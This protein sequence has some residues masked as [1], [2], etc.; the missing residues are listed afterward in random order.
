MRWSGA[1][2]ARLR[3]TRAARRLRANLARPR[4]AV[5][6][7]S[8]ENRGWILEA[9]CRELRDRFEGST[10]MRSPDEMLPRA[11]SYFFSH[12]SL[13]LRTLA[14]Q[15]DVLPQR[16][17]VLFTHPPDS[18]S[19]TTLARALNRSRAVVSMSSVHGRALI[20]NGLDPSKLL[21]SIPGVDSEMFEP[22]S[23]SGHGAVGFSGSYYPRKRPDLVADLVR[24]LPHRHFLLVGRG[25]SESPVWPRLR[26]CKNLQYV[27][28]PYG[29][30]PDL[31]KTMD[32]FVSPALLEGGPM[33][34]LE[35]MMANIV[36]VASRTGFAEDL[37]DHAENGFLFDVG[38]DVSIVSDYVEQAFT[39][40][41]DVRAT[42]QHLTWER[43]ADDVLPLL[44]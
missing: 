35:A 17:V 41:C 22:G 29:E 38:A 32:V 33:P 19:M 39:L 31:Y 16:C 15:P 10:A 21:I 13:F 43:Y 20:E 2:A 44:H 26:S 3:A 37:I 9:I 12:P 42:V 27:E 18:P 5:F 28:A 8:E 30:Y 36:P 23:R 14:L 6:V 4:D 34:L 40:T 1:D 11:G 25:W 7:V 24:A